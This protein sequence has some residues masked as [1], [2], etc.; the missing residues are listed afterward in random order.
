MNTRAA[1]VGLLLLALATTAC[2][3][4]PRSTA[5]TT[6]P[7]ATVPTPA[8]VAKPVVGVLTETF[9]DRRRP[10]PANGACPALP[11]RTL[12]TTIL[13]PATAALPAATPQPGAAPARAGGPYPLIVFAHGLDATPQFYGGL[14][15]YWA[16]AGYVVAAPRFPLSSSTSPCGPVASDV[17]NQP[18]DVSD[19]ITSVLMI[20][21]GSSGPLAG[22][23]DPTEI[24]VAGHS[25]GAIT[26]VGLVANTCC[27]DPRVK[28]AVVLA[29]AAAG[30]PDGRYDFLLSP[31]IL[32]VHGTDDP[33][34]PYADGVDVFNSAR[35][36]KGL[37]TLIGGAHGSAALV[38]EVGAAT[39]DFFD[40]Y[41]RGDAS[42]PARLAGDGRAGL[43]TMRFVATPGSTVTVAPATPAAAP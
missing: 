9:V 21:A 42:A 38:P 33:L 39:T 10:T 8:P 16:A 1:L 28:A 7:P 15:T 3:A 2:S 40:A 31:P 20:S 12:V 43:S 13:Y 18:G 11:S 36:P 24:G 29:G 27:R 35:G 32:V 4:S 25:D 23:V 5:T 22:M 17:V 37:L 19:V 14:L 6:S 41:L 30:F 26:V 34:I